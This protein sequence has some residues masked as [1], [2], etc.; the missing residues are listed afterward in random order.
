MLLCLKCLK[1]V[2]LTRKRNTHEQPPV[3]PIARDISAGSA[4]IYAVCTIMA[5]SIAVFAKNYISSLTREIRRQ[6]R[7][8][9]LHKKWQKSD[10]ILIADLRVRVSKLDDQLVVLQNELAESRKTTH[11]TNRQIDRALKQWS[12][13]IAE[14]EHLRTAQFAQSALSNATEH[15]R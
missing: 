7:A 1:R 12:V 4:V 14:L 11:D 8:I 15:T 13:F 10:F 9:K 2:K 6:K 5:C 3:A